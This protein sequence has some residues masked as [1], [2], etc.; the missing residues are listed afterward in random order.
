M[1]RSRLLV[2]SIANSAHAAPTAALRAACPATIRGR[3]A[4]PPTPPE[5]PSRFVT[6]SA[7][8]PAT[9][10]SRSSRQASVP[11]HLAPRPGPARSPTAASTASALRCGA[12][13][14]LPQR[15]AGALAHQRPLVIRCCGDERHQR[16]EAVVSGALVVHGLNGDQGEARPFDER[17]AAADPLDGLLIRQWAAAEQVHAH[18]IAHVPGVEVGDPPLHLGRVDLRRVVDQARQDPRLVHTRVPQPERQPMIDAE[19]AR[20]RP[21]LRH[22]H[23]VRAINRD[24]NT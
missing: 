23:A 8:A 24:S 10:G 18:L 9:G 3:R 17:L 15:P 12:L 6:R 19:L 21:Q 7:G 11:T 5:Q 4:F 22:R 14:D 20:E 2:G 13:A 1:I 16:G